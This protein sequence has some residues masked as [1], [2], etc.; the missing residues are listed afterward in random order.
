[1][2]SPHMGHVGGS[3]LICECD[4]NMPGF[5]SRIGATVF[6]CEQGSETS[7]DEAALITHSTPGWCWAGRQILAPCRRT[8]GKLQ[9]QGSV[10]LE[11]HHGKA[12]AVNEAHL[13]AAVLVCLVA[14]ASQRTSM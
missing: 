5:I 9:R 10:E 13:V 7:Q 12:V 3:S 6:L 4:C 8:Q 14:V 1:M 2:H 11:K